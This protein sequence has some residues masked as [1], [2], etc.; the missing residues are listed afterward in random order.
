[1]SLIGLLVVLI[2]A[3]VVVWAARAILSAFGIGDPIRTVVYVVI[4]LIVVLWAVG[5]L[6][7][8]TL[9]SLRF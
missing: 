9:G 4:V 7:G 5:Q 2:L 8:G 3:C 1:M 6:G